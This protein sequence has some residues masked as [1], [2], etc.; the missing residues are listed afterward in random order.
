MAQNI[1]S[2]CLQRKQA[3]S[4]PEKVMSDEEKARFTFRR[5]LTQAPGAL[6]FMTGQRS[7]KTGHFQPALLE[8]PDRVGLIKS[9]SDISGAIFDQ[10]PHSRYAPQQ[11]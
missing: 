4:T 6:A 11:R 9:N 1:N 3:G 2:G 8:K 7:W 10:V 5:A